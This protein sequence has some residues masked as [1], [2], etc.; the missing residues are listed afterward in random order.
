ML[1]ATAAEERYHELRCDWPG[2]DSGTIHGANAF[3]GP[4]AWQTAPDSAI[5]KPPFAARSAAWLL[6]ANF[7]RV[8]GLNPLNASTVLSPVVFVAGRR[9]VF[10][11]TFLAV[12]CHEHFQT[13][14]RGLNETPVTLSTL[15]SCN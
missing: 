8:A 4:D 7:A 2:P 14:H 13:E 6:R 9:I 15:Q 5:R 1:P 12:K 10:V 11:G 3:Q